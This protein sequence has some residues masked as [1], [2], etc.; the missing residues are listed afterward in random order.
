MR[1][2]DRLFAIVQ[3]LQGRRLTTARQLAERLSVSE[4]T[5]YRDVQDLSLSGV[6]VVGEA[7]VGYSLKKGFDLPP[8]MFDNDEIEAL[9]IGARMVGA[10]G[11][12]TLAASAERAMEKIAAVLPE[13]RRVILDA[14]Q[15]F[16]PSFHVNTEVG[17]RFEALRLAIAARQ[18]VGMAYTAAEQKNATTRRVRPLALYFWGEH[19]TLAAWCEIRNDFRSFRLDRIATLTVEAAVFSLEAGKSLADFVRQDELAT[20]CDDEQK[21]A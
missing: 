10:W 13:N 5:I 7:G 11:G 17:K 3:A 2:A 21:N 18:Y 6:P 9:L 15:V 14:T 12:T 19:W 4:R 16:A 20:W 8:I 1:R